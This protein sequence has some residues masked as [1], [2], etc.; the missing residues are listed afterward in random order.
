LG[1]PVAFIADA[2]LGSLARW[3]RL[4]GCDVLYDARLDD[5]ELVRR[6]RQSGRVLLTRDGQ[7]SRRRGVRAVFVRSERRAEQLRQVL[8]AFAGACGREPRCGEC[9]GELRRADRED[10]EGDVPPYVLVTQSE[11]RRCQGCG[12]IYW[13]GTHWQ[14][15]QDSLRAATAGCEP[16]ATT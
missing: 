1:E 13:P 10:V 11:Y 5:A 14:G 12:R 6:S 16:N 9:N 4:A 8:C 7:L 15:I 3:L 2:M